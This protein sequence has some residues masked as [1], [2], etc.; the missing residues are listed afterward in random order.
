MVLV[1][2]SLPDYPDMPILLRPNS[3]PCCF[4][5]IRYTLR[6]HRKHTGTMLYSPFYACWPRTHA[7]GNCRF[8]VLSG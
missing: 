2:E 7:F 3:A 4:S 6:L 1:L 5:K 8:A